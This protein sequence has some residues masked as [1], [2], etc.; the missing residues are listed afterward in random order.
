MEFELCLAS[1]VALVERPLLPHRLSR[2]IDMAVNPYLARFDGDKAKERLRIAD[3]LAD[4][5][6]Q[7]P[8][9]HV[10]AVQSYLR[11]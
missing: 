6:S 10:E 3:A 4:K 11:R 2:Q 5:A 8:L 7:A 9:A 1:L